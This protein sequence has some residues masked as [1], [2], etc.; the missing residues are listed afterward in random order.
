MDSRTL[1]SKRNII[2]GILSSLLTPIFGLIIKS[3]II[4]NFNVEYIGL[5]SVFA[6]MIQVLNLAELGFSSAVVVNLYKPLKEND[7]VAVQGI[8]SY[9]RQV[10]RIIGISVFCIG[11]LIS[12]LLKILAVNTSDV[13]EN[14][15]ILYFL[16]IADTTMSY[17]LFAYKEA[18]LNAVQRFDIAKTA[19]IIVYAIKN[20]MQLIAIVLL[21]NF[22]L[23]VVI[24]VICTVL[25]NLF[26]NAISKKMYKQYYPNGCIDSKIKGSI[27]E[28]IL[29]ISIGNIM[30]VSRNSMDSIVITYFWGLAVAGQYSNYYFIFNTV[31]GFSWVV[32]N[33]IQASV[34]NSVVSETVEKNYWDMTR[35]EF[36]LNIF[37]TACSAYMISLYQ[38]F[39]KVW[40]GNDLIFDDSIMILFVIY[41]Y[42]MAIN[43]GRNAYFFALGYWWKA[44]WCII[45]ESVLNII[46]N[47]I[48]GKVWGV[49]GIIIATIIT[50]IVLNYIGITNLLFREYFR[51]GKKEFYANR[52]VYTVIALTTCSISYYSSICIQYDGIYGLIIRALVCTL[53]ILFVVP[54]LMF[55]L[56][57][58]DF[59]DAIVFVKQIIKA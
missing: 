43:G 26:L 21:K 29:G 41:F 48:L 53:I 37:I 45:L 33:A 17:V 14:I 7:L 51:F 28:Q 12:P 2:V 22:Y 8:L 40:M 39:M 19:Y 42:A 10:Y 52:V 13:R 30:G 55:I 9:F 58:N 24:L 54:S 11:I 36:L 56:K 1:N 49:S 25:Y 38:P 16:Y 35:I 32:I 31:I 6:S 3:A 27:K 44:R 50:I 46:L 18:L 15:Y 47:V 23:Y 5:T 20:I 34:G 4:N 57:R 59:K